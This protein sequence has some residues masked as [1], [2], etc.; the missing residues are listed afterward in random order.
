M[1]NLEG[2]RDSNLFPYLSGPQLLF[3]F[4][5]RRGREVGGERNL[6]REAP[7]GPDGE[8][9]RGADGQ[10]KIGDGSGGGRGEEDQSGG[11]EKRTSVAISGGSGFEFWAGLLGR[12][13]ERIREGKG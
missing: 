11:G 7:C 2:H 13:V 5:L 1:V 6:A 4:Y 12:F 3:L 9:G 8:G 10:R